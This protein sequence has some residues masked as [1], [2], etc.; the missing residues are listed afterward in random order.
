M[1]KSVTGLP[2]GSTRSFCRNGVYDRGPRVSVGFCLVDM[3][4]RKTPVQKKDTLK[5]IS[6][7]NVKAKNKQ[8]S[9]QWTDGPFF[10]SLII[11][12]RG[13]Y[14]YIPTRLITQCT[15]LS[16][17]LFCGLYYRCKVIKIFDTKIGGCV[18]FWN[19]LGSSLTP[20][21]STWMDASVVW[22]GGFR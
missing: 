14:C 8:V 10:I 17:L 4:A 13:R 22:A 19:M 11:Y 7:I 2:V 12:Y 21:E 18:C 9:S 1:P 16:L 6:Q 3:T 5:S 15:S 20:V